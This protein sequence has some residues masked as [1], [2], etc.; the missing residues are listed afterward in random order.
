MSDIETLRT[1]LREPD[2]AENFSLADM[3][4]WINRRPIAEFER[5]VGWRT[6]MDQC[7]KDRPYLVLERCEGERD[8]YHVAERRGNDKGIL[9]VGGAFSFD[10]GKLVAWREFDLHSRQRGKDAT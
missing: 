10:R 7:P 4:D 1:W 5:S 8:A 2:Y 3:T 6:D 9:I